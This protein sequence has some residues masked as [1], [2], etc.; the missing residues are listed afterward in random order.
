MFLGTVQKLF[1]KEIT[2]KSAL[3]R[4]DN[5]QFIVQEQQQKLKMNVTRKLCVK[6]ILFRR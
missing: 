1:V 4:L 5:R 6:I 3:I 2:V